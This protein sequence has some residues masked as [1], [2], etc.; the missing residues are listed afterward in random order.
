[1]WLHT[2]AVE[3]CL[4]KRGVEMWVLKRGVE[5]W[6]LKRGVIFTFVLLRHLVTLPGKLI[7][8]YSFFFIRCP[9]TLVILLFLNQL[10]KVLIP[11]GTK[12]PL[13]GL[14]RK[15]V[16][17]VWNCDTTCALVS[18]NCGLL[19]SKRVALF[20]TNVKRFKF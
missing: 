1:M 11:E 12:E 15:E 9:D 17:D 10:Q 3:L 4:P 16:V 19:N 2:R 8:I 18:L 5:M 7:E 13:R 20:A 14:R 6:V